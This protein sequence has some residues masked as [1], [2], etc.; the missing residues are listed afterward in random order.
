MLI[1]VINKLQSIDAVIAH[2]E[3]HAHIVNFILFHSISLLCL[4]ESSW[5]KVKI[6]AREA[7]KACFNSHI[8]FSF[9]TSKFSSILPPGRVGVTKII[10]LI[11]TSA[12]I[13]QSKKYRSDFSLPLNQTSSYALSLRFPSHQYFPRELSY[14]LPKTRPPYARWY[15]Y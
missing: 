11:S 5:L 14:I 12:A 15:L 7:V 10:F 8:F 6:R 4:I 1:N 9:I 13:L 3:D 2:S